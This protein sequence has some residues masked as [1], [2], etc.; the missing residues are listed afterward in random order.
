MSD[1]N[2]MEGFINACANKEN[3]KLR[4]KIYKTLSGNVK[5]G[6]NDN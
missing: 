5:T 6:L 2:T 4:Y 1:S 3:I